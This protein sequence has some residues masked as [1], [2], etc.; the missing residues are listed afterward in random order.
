MWLNV[1]HPDRE[2]A[3]LRPDRKGAPGNEGGLAGVLVGPP[4][5]GLDR[6]IALERGQN[7]V[8][9]SAATQTA[10]GAVLAIRPGRHRAG[11][12][13]SER[14]RLGDPEARTGVLEAGEPRSQ[15]QS[16]GDRWHGGVRT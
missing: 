7:P 9:A 6:P 11:P 16:H 3:E 12:A 14:L 10:R 13:H 8:L 4:K 2:K 15:C 5:E 1:R